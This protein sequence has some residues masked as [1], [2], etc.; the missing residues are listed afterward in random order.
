MNLHT[1]N[2]HHELKVRIPAP[3]HLL[4]VD[5]KSISAKFSGTTEEAEYAYKRVSTN[6]EDDDVVFS[7]LLPGPGP[8]YQLLTLCILNL[9]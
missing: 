2:Q 4:I 3:I 8:V 1:F 5:L 9:K 6:D 7:S